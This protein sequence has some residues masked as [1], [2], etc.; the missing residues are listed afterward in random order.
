MIWRCSDESLVK[1]PRSAAPWCFFSRVTSALSA[2]ST[3]VGSDLVVE[4][5][6]RPAPT[7]RKRLETSD[8]QQPGRNR[9]AS[10]KPTS[11]LPHVEEHVAQ[12]VFGDRF[13]ADEPKQ[14]AVDR[15]AVPSEQHLHGE[16]VACRDARNQHF[17]GVRSP[18]RASSAPVAVS[19]IYFIQ[20]WEPKRSQ[21]IAALAVTAKQW[22]RHV[23]SKKKPAQNLTVV[24]VPRQ[25][26]TGCLSFRGV[27]PNARKR[28]SS[29]GCFSTLLAQRF[30]VRSKPN[31]STHT[32]AAPMII[33]V[34]ISS[35]PPPPRA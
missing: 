10:F 11:L 35:N 24:K 18:A 16:L 21:G 14:P 22:E 32:I 29:R 19:E 5:R 15:G 25:C 7:A 8:R 2:G 31:A 12:K 1:A 3:T 6:V 20:T 28:G 30:N 23:F 17:I 27:K 33:A 9:G 4:F 26:L 13:V 34:S